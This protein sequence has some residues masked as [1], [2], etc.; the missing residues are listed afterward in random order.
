[1]N[2]YDLGVELKDAEG[3]HFANMRA[4]TLGALTSVDGCRMTH[5]YQITLDD[6]PDLKGSGLYEAFW[7]VRN[8][9]PAACDLEKTLLNVSDRLL[10]ERVTSDF[11]KFAND[12]KGDPARAPKYAYKG[13]GATVIPGA[14]ATISPP[15]G[16]MANNN[17]DNFF[18]LLN[19]M[20]DEVDAVVITGDLYDHLHNFDPNRLTENTTGKLWEAMYL[21]NMRS[22]RSRSEDFLRSIDGK[23]REVLT[24]RGIFFAIYHCHIRSY[25]VYM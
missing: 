18:D 16:D 6:L 19:Q 10:R 5:L 23:F 2:V 11:Y 3:R 7:T 1:M 20:G 15:I 25:G 24:T 8:E 9:K 13:K 12:G 22:I 14:D 17:G 4:S 21:E